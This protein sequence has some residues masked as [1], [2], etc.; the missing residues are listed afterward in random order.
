MEA[1]RYSLLAT[2]RADGFPRISGVVAH[3]GD[4]RLR[5]AMR[6]SAAMAADL[7]REPRIAFHSGPV[8]GEGPLMDAKLQG[9]A[10]E[11]TDPRIVERFLDSL[12]H[13]AGGDVALFTIALSD[14]ESHHVITSWKVG[15]Q[16]P[17]VRIR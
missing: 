7:R 10:A 13:G 17:T 11:E 5:L 8:E 9:T 16:G 4:G 14:D 15:E 12:P 6:T 3:F 1:S 2:I